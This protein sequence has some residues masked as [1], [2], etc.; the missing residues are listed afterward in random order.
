MNEDLL[1]YKS[2]LMNGES[3][4]DNESQ[5]KNLKKLEKSA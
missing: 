3:L 5:K 4:E 1:N 2:C